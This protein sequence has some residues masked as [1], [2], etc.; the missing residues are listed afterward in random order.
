MALPVAS[1]VGIL[2][3]GG[4]FSGDSDGAGLCIEVGNIAIPGSER[5][6]A[7]SPFISK[8]AG[9]RSRCAMRKECNAESLR[10]NVL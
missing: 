3:V 7:L 10:I 6:T 2:G 1:G 8:F 9:F 4:D 5:N